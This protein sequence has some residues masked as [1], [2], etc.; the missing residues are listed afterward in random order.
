MTYLS[1]II[2]R[3][4]QR[5]DDALH[6]M[7]LLEEAQLF[8]ERHFANDIERICTYQSSSDHGVII[9]L[10]YCN[11]T[12]ISNASSFSENSFNRVNNTRIVLSTNGS[13]S[14]TVF[15]EY[16]ADTGR[17]IFAW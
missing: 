4:L 3:F 9:F 2:E 1:N 11:H 5:R 12:A 7:A 16:A 14:A 10:Q 15:I 17:L 8:A 6:I 13:N